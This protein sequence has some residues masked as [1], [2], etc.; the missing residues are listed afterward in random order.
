MSLRSLRVTLAMALSGAALAFE[1]GYLWVAYPRVT[2]VS[3][4]A[5]V[6]SL[7]AALVVIGIVLGVVPLLVYGARLGRFRPEKS[8]AIRA[9]FEIMSRGT[10]VPRLIGGTLLYAISLYALSPL[11]LKVLRQNSPINTIGAILPVAFLGVATLLVLSA[12][13]KLKVGGTEDRERKPPVEYQAEPNFTTTVPWA[14][15]RGLGHVGLKKIAP[16]S[17]A[18]GP[19]LAAMPAQPAVSHLNPPMSTASEVLLGMLPAARYGQSNYDLIVTDQ[20]IVGAFLG[21]SGM[22]QAAGFLLGGVIG[23]AVGA[24]ISRGHEAQ[25]ARYSGLSVD[26]VFLS[27]QWNFQVALASLDRAEFNAGINMITMPRLTLWIGERKSS[28]SSCIATGRRTRGK[29]NTSVKSSRNLCPI[30]FD[31]SGSENRDRCRFATGTE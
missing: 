15:A 9:E 26:Q 14:A 3:T 2:G 21:D 11:L 29:S 30:G 28:S 18:E 23:Y 24:G 27:H 6:M 7:W 22:A 31:S 17:P 1:G 4:E 8:L 10:S 13:R 5:P 19:S 25:R 12:P 20:R 16:G